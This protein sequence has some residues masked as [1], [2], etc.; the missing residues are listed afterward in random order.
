MTENE[1]IR[2]H[3]AICA[4]LTAL[5]KKKNRDY[6]DAFHASFLE[7]GMA[8][9]RIRLGDKFNRFKNLT[10]SGLRQVVDESIRDTLIDLANYAIL[11]VME[12]DNAKPQ[13]ALHPNPPIFPAANPL[14]NIGTVL[15]RE[16]N[17]HE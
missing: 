12:I 11:T 13:P 15:V 5:Y 3:E 6:G 4:E 16:V 14:G 1:K 7:E 10:R 9:P 8:M 17:E 2:Q